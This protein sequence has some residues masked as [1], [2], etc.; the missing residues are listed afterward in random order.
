MPHIFTEQKKKPNI[1]TNKHREMI[2]YK[3][4]FQ[5]CMYIFIFGFH[6][7]GRI[8]MYVTIPNFLL[9]LSAHENAHHKEERERVR[10]TYED[11]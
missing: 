10:E 7:I 5:I 2:K 8:S 4:K 11:Y 6:F 9:F 3:D 1:E